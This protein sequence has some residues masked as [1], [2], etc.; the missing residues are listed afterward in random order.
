MIALRVF[1]DDERGALAYVRNPGL[2]H[3]QAPSSGII[4]ASPPS[5]VP[6]STARGW[7]HSKLGRS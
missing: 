1:L 6:I 2:S 5:S 4:E 7:A 3:D